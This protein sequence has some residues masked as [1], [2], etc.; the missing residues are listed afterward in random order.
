MLEACRLARVDEFAERFPEGYDT[1]VG[2]RGVKLSGGQRQRVSIARAI[3]ADPRILIL[4]EATSSL[5]SESEALIQEGL[6]HLMQ[7]RTT[8]VIAHRLSTIRRADQILVVEEGRIVERGTHDG[9]VRCAR[10][11]LRDV[12]DSS[13]AWSEPVPGPRR[14][15]CGSGMIL[16]TFVL[17]LA[18]AGDRRLAPLP[19][20]ERHRDPGTGRLPAEL[21]ATRNVVW[22]TALPPGYSSPVVSGDRIFV[23]AFEGEKLLTIALD[24]ATG[25]ERWRRESPRDRREKLDPRNG[26]AS[27]TPVADG[28]N[29]YVFFPDYGL[30]SYTFAGEERW[31]TPL[32]PFNNVYGMG[33]SPVL[34]GDLVVLVC[35]Q[36]RGSFAAGFRQSDGREVW[37]TPRP[38]A[39][40]G[41][42]T[43]IVYEPP[44][45]PLQVV[46]PGSFRMDNYAVATGESVSWVNGLPG[47][48][49]SGPVL[50]GD[51]I[52]I[53]GF[54]TPDNDPG[55]QVIVP[56]FAEVLA[57]QDADKDGKISPAEAP[58]E[59]TRR[60]FAFI[61][62]DEDGAADAAEWR[63]WTVG[64]ASENGLLAFRAGGRG[65]RDREEPA[66]ALF[67]LGAPAAHDARLPRRAV[68]DQRRRHPDHV[69]RGHRRGRGSR[70]A[71]AAPSTTTTRRPWPATARS[72][73]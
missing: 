39:L 67:A 35:D 72:T 21:S 28:K 31:R 58:D 57:K 6:S 55:Q 60:Y 12:H 13:T 62:L 63:I 1:I 54:S 61:D 53:N 73:S 7:G 64:S 16:L 5:D 23:T 32:G 48:M 34:A 22:K 70:P 56:P 69:R 37:R 51:I 44:G 30:L 18:G 65:D 40:S 3:L 15:G 45:G 19:R 36:N 17:L 27:P 4:D 9:A 42:S 20:P 2:E 38:D 33:A 11:L 43:P 66:L 50:V 10:P 59:R 49:K 25:K 14:R 52:Y 8:F 29:V 71:C 26:P 24:R 46:A 41:H 68:H 47:E